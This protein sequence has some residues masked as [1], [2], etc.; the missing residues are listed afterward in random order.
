MIAGPESLLGKV[1]PMTLIAWRTWKL[2]SVGSNDAEVQS[3]LEAEDQN[4]RARLL[5]TELHAAHEK[6]TVA[7][8]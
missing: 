1:G 7:K 2:Q 5:C 3:I 8:T 4:F 6:P